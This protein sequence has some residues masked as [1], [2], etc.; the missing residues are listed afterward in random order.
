MPAQNFTKRLME[1][2][3]K[4]NLRQ[5]PWKGE[6]DP[7]RIWLSEII[8][9]QTR[10]EQ[11]RAYYERF[12]LVFPTIQNLAEAPEQQVFKCWEGLGYYS[13][14]RNLIATA[15]IIVRD[16]DGKF[17]GNY[18][19]ILALPGIGPYTAAAIASFAFHLPYAVVDGNVQRVISRY[20]GIASPT[21]KAAEKTCMRPWPR[22]CS[23]KRIPAPTTRRSWIL[24][25]QSASP[26][27]HCVQSVRNR[28]IV[29]HSAT[30]GPPRCPLSPFGC[31]RK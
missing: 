17:P 29:R 14:C 20:F 31:K 3:R 24:A 16:R 18:T 4:S 30:N 6:T 7:Y 28:S 12:L 8:L 23:T 26:S 15:K 27:S 22:T 2:N 21:V 10:V 5:M 13:R 11:G 1:W 25:P 9:Q 19:E